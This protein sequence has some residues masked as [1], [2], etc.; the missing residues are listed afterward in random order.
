MK[1]EKSLF[2]FL[3]V[4]AGSVA[5]FTHYHVPPTMGRS[6][7]NSG[8]HVRHSSFQRNL[9]MS[10]SPGKKNLRSRLAAFKHSKRKSS[11]IASSASMDFNA[12]PSMKRILLNFVQ[13]IQMNEVTM[14]R[15]AATLF[16]SSIF[17]FSS[18]L[19]V[20]MVNLWSWLQN[21]NALLPRLFRHDHWE[22]GVAITAFF[23]WIHGFWLADRAVAKADAKGIVH[24]WKKFRLQ[25]QYEAEKFRRTQVRKLEG[26]VDVDMDKKPPTT[27][28]NKWHM[29]FWIFELPL[30]VLPLYIWDICIPRRA[31]KL[32]AWGAPTALR[33]CSD[34]TCA[35][36]LYDLGFFVCHYL[37]HKIPFLYKYV[38]A[39]HHKSTEVRASDIVRLSFVE[40]IV[41][42]SKR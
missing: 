27:R 39:K 3:G 42:V 12:K 18:A 24:P 11:S 21:G 15:I 26:G 16:I 22:W 2:I 10:T 29:G 32:S 38:H 14:W 1:F 17:T 7:A 23:F 25:D 31:A 37:M 9:S 5:G 35:L 33:V 40:E 30:Y 8:M 28:Q 36:L 20:Q 6:N 13:K 19:D 4:A 41:D 34:V